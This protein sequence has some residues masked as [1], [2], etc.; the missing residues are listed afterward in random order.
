MIHRTLDWI[1]EVNKK[2]RIVPELILDVGSKETNGSP[3]HLFPNSNYL[4]IDIR[5]GQ[6][7][8][9]VLSVYDLAKTFQ[10]NCFDAILCLHALEHFVNI[11]EDVDQMNFVLRKGGYFYVAI[12]GLGFPKHEGKSAGGAK[13]YWRAT[14]D[15]VCE[16]IMDGYDILSLEH[17]RSRYG[18]HPLI[19]CLGVKK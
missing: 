3:R 6:N 5:A 12:P 10:K 1:G 11:W 8:D 7:V 17:A 9:R 4:G 19:N 14:E 15:A 2:Y 18:K 13:D 16:M